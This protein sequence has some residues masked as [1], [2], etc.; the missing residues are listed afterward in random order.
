V[1]K[2]FA[3]ENIKVLPRNKMLARRFTGFFKRENI[4]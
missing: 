4:S 1:N 3:Q 2:G